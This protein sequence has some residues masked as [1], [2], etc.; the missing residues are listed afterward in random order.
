MQAQ[1]LNAKRSGIIHL[2]YIALLAQIVSTAS[3]AAKAPVKIF[4]PF[5]YSH[6]K[7]GQATSDGITLHP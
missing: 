6:S 7:A 1:V 5:R 3:A 2:G 4:A